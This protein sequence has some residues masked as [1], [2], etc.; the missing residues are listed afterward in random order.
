M[1]ITCRFFLKFVLLCEVM[2]FVVVPVSGIG[3][4]FLPK[5][6]DALTEPE[7]PLWSR[8]S[9]L[10][11]IWCKF[12][13]LLA[14]LIKELATAWCGSYSRLLRCVKLRFESMT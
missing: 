5:G 3:C 11:D 2:L 8:R 9:R 6:Y 14:G 7:L 4:T 12:D 10:E 1:R 13:T